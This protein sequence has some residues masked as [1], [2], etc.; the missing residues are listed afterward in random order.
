M[1]LDICK[2]CVYWQGGDGVVWCKHGRCYTEAD[3]LTHCY[4]SK[5]ERFERRQTVIQFE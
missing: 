2:R 4:V 3:H 5:A 1:T